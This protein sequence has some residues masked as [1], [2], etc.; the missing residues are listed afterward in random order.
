[1]HEQLPQIVRWELEQVRA[2]PGI[3]RWDAER[4]FPYLLAWV[5]S[6][7]PIYVSRGPDGR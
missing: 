1:M 7:G 5:R 2:Y 4:T 3:S 6:S